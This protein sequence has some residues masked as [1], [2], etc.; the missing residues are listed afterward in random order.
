MGWYNDAPT[1]IDPNSMSGLTQDG[2]SLTAKDERLRRLAMQSE[3]MALANQEQSQQN[4]MAQQQRVGQWEADRSQIF[5][6]YDT[7]PVE[8]MA[9]DIHSPLYTS[10]GKPQFQ[11]ADE[12]GPM[13]EVDMSRQ[14]IAQPK[15]DAAMA[16]T[17]YGS[18]MS[19]LSDTPE[20][21]NQRAVLDSLTG[22]LKALSELP[23]EGSMP[24]ILE[25][26]S[27]IAAIQGKMMPGITSGAPQP[28]PAPTGGGSLPGA[29]QS[30]FTPEQE[31]RIAENV[32]L[33]GKSREEVIAQMRAKGRL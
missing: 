14:P 17:K 15:W 22:E 8:R 31:K 29:V 18:G 25:L 4:Q 20:S 26:R 16:N 33:H 5:H 28:N 30:Q 13:P 10:P 23:V 9:T 7:M 3:A 12:A 11:W 24:R 2:E 19:H 27:Q 6:P 1:R 32:A 21:R